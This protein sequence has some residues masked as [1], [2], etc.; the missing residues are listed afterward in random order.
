MT[1]VKACKCFWDEEKKEI[2]SAKPS[3]RN[4]VTKKAVLQ[5]YKML[6]FQPTSWRVKFYRGENDVYVDMMLT[7]HTDN[8]ES[9]TMKLPHRWHDGNISNNNWDSPP[10]HVQITCKDWIYSWV[11]FSLHVWLNIIKSYLLL[12]QDYQSLQ[13]YLSPVIPLTSKRNLNMVISKLIES[14][15]KQ[16]QDFPTNSVFA[17]GVQFRF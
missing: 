5:F 7:N 3:W 4:D 1:T 17:R 14:S 13:P 9:G 16:S 6:F 12:S 15:S 2:A 8:Y 10:A 11:W